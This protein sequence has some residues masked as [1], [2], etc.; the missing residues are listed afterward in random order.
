MPITI[1]LYN[2]KVML[3]HMKKNPDAYQTAVLLKSFYPPTLQ[4]GHWASLSEMVERMHNQKF[5]L[6]CPHCSESVSF[7]KDS[8]STSKKSEDDTVTFKFGKIVYCLSVP[9][10]A[11]STPMGWG[12]SILQRFGIRPYR[13]TAQERII[14]AL[15]LDSLSMKILSK[16]KIVFSS[17]KETDNLQDFTISKTLT[18]QTVDDKHGLA[19]RN[20]TPRLLV[21]GTSR[22]V[23]SPKTISVKDRI[24]KASLYDML[25]W[26]IQ[27]F[28]HF[29]AHLIR[30]LFLGKSTKR[31]E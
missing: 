23:L 1:P 19:A 17:S 12:E 29:G 16:G 10:G 8:A 14:D 9:G 7:I 11:D 15:Q 4:C 20:T 27:A 13:I 21:V 28:L 30:F 24:K 3:F 31:Q 25:G 22:S 26:T 18:D 6:K 2:N 5:S